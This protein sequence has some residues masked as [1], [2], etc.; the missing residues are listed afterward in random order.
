MGKASKDKGA[1]EMTELTL[2]KFAVALLRSSAAPGV[3]YFHCPNGAPTSAR[4]GARMKAMGL[5]AG[6]ADLV[7]VRP[8]GLVYFLELKTAKGSL[9]IAQRAFR[10]ACEANG[11]PYAV[12]Y[13]PERVE[14]VLRGWD[15]L[16]SVTKMPVKKAA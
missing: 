1:W 8:G 4:T 14:A 3:I 6:V 9:S 10:D 2:Q 16:R 13:S 7:I 15:V 11:V 5:L 12:A